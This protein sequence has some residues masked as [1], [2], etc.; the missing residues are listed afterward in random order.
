MDAS[1]DVDALRDLG[2]SVDLAATPTHGYR[3]WRAASSGVGRLSNLEVGN[4]TFLCKA[5][6]WAA[7]KAHSDLVLAREG[8]EPK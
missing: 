4:V 7:A 8:G 2:Y 3:W 1:V 5:D 6:A